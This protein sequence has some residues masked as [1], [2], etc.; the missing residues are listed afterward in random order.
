MSLYFSNNNGVTIIASETTIKFYNNTLAPVT[1]FYTYTG[2]D[3]SVTIPAVYNTATIECWGAG[4]ATKGQG[5][6]TV[7]ITGTSG[8]GGY[9]KATFFYS[10]FIS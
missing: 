2:A 7:Y 8:G 3:Q 1:Y 10:K 6:A 9:T 4:G 5:G